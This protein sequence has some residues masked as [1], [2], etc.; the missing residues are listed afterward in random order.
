MDADDKFWLYRQGREDAAME[1]ERTARSA[2][3]GL[4]AGLID[5]DLAIEMIDNAAKLNVNG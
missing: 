2:I 4:A 3:R 5:A 1:V